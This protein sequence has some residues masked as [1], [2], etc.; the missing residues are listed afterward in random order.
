M[1]KP[2][3]TIGEQQGVSPIILFTALGLFLILGI[4]LVVLIRSRRL[5]RSPRQAMAYAAGRKTPS[6][7]R[8]AQAAKL[9]PDIKNGGDISAAIKSGAEHEPPVIFE[10]RNPMIA[11]FVDDQNT[12]IGRRNVHSLKA[13]N[14]YTLGGGKSDYLIFLVPLPPHI[15]ELRFDGKGCTF[16]PTK[17]HYFPD[18]GSEP[19]P[20][21]IGKTIRVVSDRDYQ[22][23]FRMQRYENPLT[24][25]NQLMQSI[26]VS[27]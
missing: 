26:N 2:V 10:D 4:A 12:N 23:T 1:V 13:G 7:P 25:L 21:C 24:A 6:K 16:V 8:E 20:N 19:V 18:I 11:L 5:H 14:S 22:L 17:P 15:G 3:R 27:N 9:A